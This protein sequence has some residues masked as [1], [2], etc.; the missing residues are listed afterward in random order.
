MIS[1]IYQQ[2]DIFCRSHPRNFASNGIMAMV[3]NVMNHSMTDTSSTEKAIQ[4]FRAVWRLK[5]PKMPLELGDAGIKAY[6]RRAG[7]ITG[8]VEMAREDLSQGNTPGID[9]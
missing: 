6:L 7:T 3:R 5:T 9:Y 8:A 1:L 4:A 2:G